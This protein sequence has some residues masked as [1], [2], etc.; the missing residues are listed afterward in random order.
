M[1]E[2]VEEL[3]FYPDQRYLAVS[4]N[5]NQV[6]VFAFPNLDFY[7]T[8]QGSSSFISHLDWSAD[9]QYIRTNDGSY[10]LLH[11][12]I[13]KGTCRPHSSTALKDTVWATSTCCIS[14]AT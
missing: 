14:W 8:L 10:E 2:W 13:N 3:K 5:D 6:Y 12:A 9:S 7:C 4:S 1:K 11:Y